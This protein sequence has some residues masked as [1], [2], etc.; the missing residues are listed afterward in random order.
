MALNALLLALLTVLLAVTYGPVSHYL[1][2]IGAWRHPSRRVL[3]TD[4]DLVKIEDTIICED[5]HLYHPTNTLFSAC[6][7]DFH[8]RFGWF[9]PLGNFENPPQ[10]TEGGGSIHIID[11][12]VCSRRRDSHAGV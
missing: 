11:P 8:R 1:T 12:E 5:L 3:A 7:D 4:S 9:P 2:V 6:E 10:S